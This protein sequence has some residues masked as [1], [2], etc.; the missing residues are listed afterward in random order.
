ME[1]R[2]NVMLSKRSQNLRVY[3][4]GD[5]SEHGQH[6]LHL[7]NERSNSSNENLDTVKRQNK[8]QL[9]HQPV[10]TTLSNQKS[11]IK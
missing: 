3:T 10:S 9:G 5:E 8:C 1:V 7:P 4:M 11:V 6:L 2:P